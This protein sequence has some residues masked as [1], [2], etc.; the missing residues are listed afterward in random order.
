MLSN[1]LQPS[2]Q[3]LLSLLCVKIWNLGEIIA[4]SIIAT[5]GFGGKYF[6]IT[7]SLMLH[8]L[9][10]QFIILLLLFFCLDSLIYIAIEDQSKSYLMLKVRKIIFFLIRASGSI[11]FTLCVLSCSV[12]SDSLQAHEL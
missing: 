6:V 12:V 1:N 10:P 3:Q 8:V 5:D 4:G 11:S 2:W 7:R 9:S